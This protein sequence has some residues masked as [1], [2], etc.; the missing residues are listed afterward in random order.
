MTIEAPPAV[1]TEVGQPIAILSRKTVP[2]STALTNEEQRDRGRQLART[3]EDHRTEESR[4]EGMKREMKFVL[5]GLEA[6]RDRLSAIVSRGEELRDVEV[7]ERADYSIAEY[8]RQR[9]DTGEVLERRKLRENER[10]VPME[11]VS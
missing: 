6:E 3:I 1:D 11:G 10:Q 8:V 2:L 7:E 4:Q 5:A 9:M